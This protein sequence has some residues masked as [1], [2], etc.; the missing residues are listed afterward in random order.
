VTTQRTYE[1]KLSIH[2]YD[3]HCYNLIGDRDVH[4]IPDL[5]NDYE[6]N[7]IRVT[8]IVEDLD[9]EPAPDFGEVSDGFH[10]FNELYEFRKLYNAALFNEWA[11]EGF[12]KPFYDVHKS[13][14]HH[15]GT[16]PFEN[17]PSWFIVVAQLP[18]GQIS[19][20][21]RLDDWDLFQIPE[22]DRAAEFDGHSAADA[23]DRLRWF[24]KGD[25]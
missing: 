15:D 1:G 8:M 25:Y 21:Y 16:V 22:R 12:D 13:R 24:L 20:H 7:R 14:L 23:A 19:N 5:L 10:T 11:L 17:D 2:D 9:A 3:G 6:D 18:T 4:T